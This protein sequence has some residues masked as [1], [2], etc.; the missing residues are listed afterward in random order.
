MIQGMKFV[1]STNG[2]TLRSKGPVK[3]V[4]K[5]EKLDIIVPEGATP[6]QQLAVTH[7]GQKVL[8]AVPEGV[9]P[10]VS[11]PSTFL[12]RRPRKARGVG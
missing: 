8:V 9:A 6:G 7:N 11:L 2:P 5:T 10:G 1:S 12:G 4:A 3:Y